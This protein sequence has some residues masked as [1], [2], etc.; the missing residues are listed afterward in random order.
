LGRSIEAIGAG[1]FQR[2]IQA[3][4][5]CACRHG[6]ILQRNLL[7]DD[8]LQELDTCLSGFSVQGSRV[9]KGACP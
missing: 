6:V 5:S 8:A 9:C 3:I 4:A 7:N 1:G 2:S